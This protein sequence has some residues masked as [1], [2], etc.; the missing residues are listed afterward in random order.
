TLLTFSAAQWSTLESGLNYGESF[1]KPLTKEQE[2]AVQEIQA[3]RQRVTKGNFEQFIDRLEQLRQIQEQTSQ[4]YRHSSLNKLKY[5]D[6]ITVTQMGDREW[7]N[8]EKVVLQA[9]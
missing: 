4:N 7:Q 6:L 2:Y 3:Y 5:A 1:A 9:G 8:L